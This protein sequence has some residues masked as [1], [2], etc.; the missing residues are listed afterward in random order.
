MAHFEFYMLA[1]EENNIHN[2]ISIDQATL[3]AKLINHPQLFNASKTSFKDSEALSKTNTTPGLPKLVL[4]PS[5]VKKTCTKNFETPNME[6]ELY[7]LLY[8][9]SIKNMDSQSPIEKIRKHSTENK[10][11]SWNETLPPHSGTTHTC[12]E[13]SNV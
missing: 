13:E 2:I 4:T 11:D 8:K 3:V 1:M 12:T 6:L 9:D 10:T 5:T 7:L